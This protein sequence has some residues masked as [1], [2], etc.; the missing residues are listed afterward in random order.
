MRRNCQR[1]LLTSCVPCD[2]VSQILPGTASVDFGVEE[3][4]RA[5]DAQ[6]QQ[7]LSSK[8]RRGERWN[9]AAGRLAGRHCVQKALNLSNPCT[10]IIAECN[11]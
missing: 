2:K 8:E 11:C 10:K 3:A 1:K 6:S 9:S 7:L 5:S 4:R